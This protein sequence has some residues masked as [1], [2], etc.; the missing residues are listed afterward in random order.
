MSSLT[1]SVPSLTEQLPLQEAEILRVKARKARLDRLRRTKLYHY[2]PQKKQREFHDAGVQ[3]NERLFLA[4]NRVGKTEC[5]AA[6]VA[7]HLTGAYPEWWE[8]RRFNEP[9]RVW[10]GGVTAESTRDIIQEKLIGEPSDETQWGTGY[11]PGDLMGKPTMRR[12][13]PNA[14]ESVTVTHVTGG[15]S[16]I[17]FKSYDQQ[18]PKWQGTSRHVIWLDEECSEELYFEALTR[19]NDV[20]GIVFMTFTPLLGMSAVVRRFLSDAD[21]KG[22]LA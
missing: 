21:V 17:G 3:H 15:S 12:N 22:M 18:R 5:G 16:T 11:I 10:V 20:N 7:L 8:G 6:E 9:V 2:I 13:V 1:V 14:V 19:T 4:A